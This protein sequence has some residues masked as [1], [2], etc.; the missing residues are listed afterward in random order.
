M[1]RVVASF[2]RSGIY[3]AKD[4]GIYEEK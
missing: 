1:H 3:I 2:L 4:R